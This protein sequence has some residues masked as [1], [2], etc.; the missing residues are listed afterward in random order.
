MIFGAIGVNGIDIAYSNHIAKTGMA[1]SVAGSH[2]A[3]AD[4]ADRK[5]IVCGKLG[6]FRGGVNVRN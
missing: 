6:C 2:A 4:A 3:N 1:L 5:S